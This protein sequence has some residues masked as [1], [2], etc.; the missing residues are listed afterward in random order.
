MAKRGERDADYVIDLLDELIGQPAVREHCF[1]W[2]VGDPGRNGARRKLPVDAYWPHLKFVIEYREDQHYVPTPIMDRRDT[3]S[4][5]PRG[6][7]RRLYDQRRDELIPA[8]GLR[9]LVI[10]PH[11]LRV[12]RRDRLL[13]DR[14]GDLEL[15]RGVLHAAGIEPP[16]STSGVPSPNMVRIAVVFPAPLGPTKPVSRPGCTWNEHADRAATSP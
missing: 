7:Q 11:E 2:L 14:A 6:E 10:R 4:G 5:V 12:A 16:A 1:E 9:L 3:I 15:L 13:R 8:N